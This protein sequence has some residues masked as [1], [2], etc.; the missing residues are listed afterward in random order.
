[1]ELGAKGM[2]HGARSMGQRAWSM[3]LLGYNVSAFNNESY[4]FVIRESKYERS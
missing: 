3:G 4:K 1:M 2:G